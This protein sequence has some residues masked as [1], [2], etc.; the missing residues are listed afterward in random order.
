MLS[1]NTLSA[2]GG[3]IALALTLSACSGSDSSSRAFEPDHVHGLSQESGGQILIATHDG[4]F[5]LDGEGSPTPVNDRTTDLMGFTVDEE[6]TFFA[7]GHPG[8]G[9][10]GPAALGLITSTDGG[11]SFQEVSLGG[12]ADFHSLAAAAGAIYG[13]D[14]GTRLMRTVDNGQSWEQIELPQP[15]ADI[16]VDPATETVLATSQV[17]LLRSEDQGQSFEIAQGAPTLLLVDWSPD[18]TLV[19]IDPSGQVFSATDA[20]SWIPGARIDPPQALVATADGVVYVA[21]EKALLRS[22]DSG[23][24]FTTVSEW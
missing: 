1:T 16:A 19:G 2:V 3:T 5:A 15:V 7:S 9:E 11:L 23:S 13:V 21:T 10:D 18:G 22:D 8:P 6:G 20:E 4:L 14:G 12:E 17:G 24:S